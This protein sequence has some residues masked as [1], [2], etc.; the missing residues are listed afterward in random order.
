MYR[1]LLGVRAAMATADAPE[2]FDAE[3]EQIDLAIHG[4]PKPPATDHYRNMIL[5]AAISEVPAV[6]EATPDQLRQ[7]VE[8][9][10]AIRRVR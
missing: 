5:V 3:I 10:I 2:Q 9:L 8:Q 6:K 7:A 4:C 1:T